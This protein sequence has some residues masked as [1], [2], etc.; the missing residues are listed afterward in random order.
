MGATVFYISTIQEH[1][2]YKRYLDLI[3]EHHMNF[4]IEL[5]K[6]EEGKE[7]GA[8][9]KKHFSRVQKMA[10]VANKV[11]I[12]APKANGYWHEWRS[13]FD[14]HRGTYKPTHHHWCGLGIRDSDTGKPLNHL[15]LMYTN[16]HAIPSHHCRCDGV[17]TAHERFATSSQR[18]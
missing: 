7:A 10:S 15:T 5:P 8:R 9:M 6:K 3:K 2:H 16:D 1:A 14:E 18:G 4:I 13:W 12:L 17:Q 11:Y